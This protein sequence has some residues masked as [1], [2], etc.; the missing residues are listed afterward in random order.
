MT[1]NSNS[2]QLTSFNYKFELKSL[3]KF[4]IEIK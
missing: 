1:K 2:V 4:N 3:L